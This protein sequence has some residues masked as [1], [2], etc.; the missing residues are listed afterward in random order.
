MR[1]LVTAGGFDRIGRWA[2]YGA[3]LAMTPY[4]LIKVSWVAQALAGRYDGD[5]TAFVALNIVTIGMAAVAILVALALARPWG[6]RVRATPLVVGGWLGGGFLVSALPYLAVQA[7]L[8]D[9]TEGAGTG[10]SGPS[11]EM[12]LLQTAFVG[13]G[14]GLALALPAYVARRWP[15]AARV[16]AARAA[17]GRRWP[18][19][20][21]ALVGVVLLQWA[22][23]SPLGLT[24]PGDRAPHWHAFHA[25]LGGWALVGA[26]GYLALVRHR[27]RRA[28]WLP[29]GAVWLTSG[30]LVAWHGW[31]LPFILVASAA[32]RPEDSWFPEHLGLL[33]VIHVVAVAAGLGMISTLRGRRD[34]ATSYVVT[35]ELDAPVEV[36]WQ[37]LSDVEAMPRW[38]PSMTRVR[39]AGGRPLGL[40]SRVRI[41]Q[42]KLLPATWTVHDWRPVGGFA[43]HSRTTG[44]HTIATHR[45]LPA[46][47]RRSELT[48]SI[49]MR[50]A[51]ARPMW[52]MVAG[53]IRR[54]V[55]LELAGLAEAAEQRAQSAE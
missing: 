18:A 42:P 4:L 1:Q 33:V 23:G 14:A 38:T 32:G 55:D 2:G 9:P 34:R 3:A 6:Q 51:F 50:G 39:I 10:S 47:G 21:A 11:W 29:V 30:A 41:R 37:V 8:S 28:A 12:A 35:R 17:G 46:G 19:A 24:V 40:G 31:K 43:W 25:V 16:A 5:A 27:I 7:F 52:R 53:T 54:Y 49:E 26:A 44:V 22:A 36:V 48:L 20:A 15:A 13:M 45:I